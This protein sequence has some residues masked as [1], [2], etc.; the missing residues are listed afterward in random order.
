VELRGEDLSCYFNIIPSVGL[1]KCVYDLAN[2]A[3]IS[4]ITVKNIYQSFTHKMATK[5]SK[6]RNYVTVILCTDGQSSEGFKESATHR[7]CV[8]LV[9]HVAAVVNS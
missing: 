1:Y 6:H 7:H 3:H 5:A 8:S 4:N 9:A 2:K